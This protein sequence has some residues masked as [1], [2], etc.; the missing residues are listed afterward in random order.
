MIDETNYDD[1]VVRSKLDLVGCK[2]PYHKK[3][4]NF[5]ICQTQKK[6][7]EAAFDGF[8][9][10]YGYPPPCRTF[11]GIFSSS[12]ET[13]DEIGVEKNPLLISLII[14]YNDKV[15]IITQLRQIDAQALVGYIG[16]YIGL[17]LGTI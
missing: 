6:M 8:T 3:F 13:N 15:K 9:A 7:K 14:W 11:S 5:S 17:I 1:F 10:T 16:G 2:T 12:K 4:E